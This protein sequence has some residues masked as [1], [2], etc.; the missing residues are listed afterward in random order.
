M[1][2][3]GK[4][5][6]GRLPSS[7]ESFV[8]TEALE[9][10]ISLE[11]LVKDWRGATGRAR[12]QLK[13]ALIREMAVIARGMH[14]AGLNH[15]DFYLCHFLVMDRDWPEWQLG[16][17]LALHL[18]DLHRV[19]RRARVPARWVIKDLAALLCSAFDWGVTLRDVAG[20]IEVYQ[21]KRWSESAPP[22]RRFWRK[23]GRRAC[24][25]FRGFYKRPP[26]KS[27]MGLC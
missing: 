3:A 16:D 2:V 7:L 27:W 4:G 6:R 19:Q 25:L 8:I 21:G 13:R 9:G 15:R 18:I 10:M 14:D 26:P 23:V 12:L 1:T 17:P 11:D 5:L 24:S 22:V 20:F